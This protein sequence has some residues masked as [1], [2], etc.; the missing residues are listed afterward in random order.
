MQAKRDN[1]YLV[2]PVGAGK[3]TIGKLLAE[4][5]QL[6][7][8][9]SDMEIESASGAD[10]RWIFDVEGED[11]FRRREQRMIETLTAKRGIVL[12]TGGGTVLAERNRQL[13]KAGGLVIYLHATVAQQVERAGRD[14]RR[15]LLAKAA[16]PE[17]AVE[18]LMRLREPLY[19]ELADYTFNTSQRNPQ[20]MANEIAEVLV[21]AG[22]AEHAHSKRQAG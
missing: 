10:I 22:T 12:A 6:Q 20:A 15:P 1:I 3:T 7:F 17:A 21:G 2:G 14:R 8:Y 19:S 4:R 5:L 9:D 11:G 16:D 13:L 18:E